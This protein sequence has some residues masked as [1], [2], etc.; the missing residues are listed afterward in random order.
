MIHRMHSFLED[1]FQFH[2]EILSSTLMLLFT[3]CKRF[4]IIV[5]YLKNVLKQLT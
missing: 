3:I 5:K 4:G 2:G 1:F